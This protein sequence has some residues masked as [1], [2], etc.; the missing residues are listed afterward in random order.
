[1]KEAIKVFGKDYL[2]L[3]KHD[4]AFCKAHWKGLVLISM[5]YGGVVYVIASIDA[6]ER[7]QNKIKKFNETIDGI[8]NT[9]V[10]M[11]KAE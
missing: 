8:N 9:A 1:M 6:E 2:D 10:K 4:L 3:L 5:V 11:V 7:F